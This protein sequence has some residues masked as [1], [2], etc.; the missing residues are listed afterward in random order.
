MKTISRSIRC[1]IGGY[2]A[3][4]VLSGCGGSQSPVVPA[5]HIDHRVASTGRSDAGRSWMASQ[6]KS[7]DL[8][9]VSNVQTNDVNVYA[10]P[11]HRL[12][13]TLTGL[14]Q[15]RSECVDAAGDVWIADA[16]GFELVEYAH[17][18]TKPIAALSTP[19]R[20][21][22]C[23]VDP[24]TGNLAVSGGINPVVVSIYRY[25]GAHHSWR[26]EN[27]Y[28]DAAVRLAYF[29]GYD[30]RGN[31]FIDGVTGREFRFAELPHRSA[32]FTNITLS[33]SIKSP[34]QV[35]WDGK[36]IAVG[37]SGVSPSVIY[38]FSVS[39]SSGTEVGSTT[40]DGTKS[41]KQFWI[42]SKTVIGPDGDNDDVGFWKYPAGGSAA[43]LIGAVDGYGA[44]VSAAKSSSSP[45]K[46]GR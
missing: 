15:P 8:L 30:S 9:Y 33:Q 20:P 39:G 31:L 29:C 18:G 19:G 13:G 1:A 27:R 21:N 11:G 44:A 2:V 41:V 4:A 3:V 6:A 36:H 32:T 38:Q 7:E 34:G 46:R 12:V 10:Y 16:E 42:Q 28:T 23:S 24:T 14:G 17:G 43:G 5:V 37:D 35:Q 26:Y 40:L 25:Y 22:G 45:P